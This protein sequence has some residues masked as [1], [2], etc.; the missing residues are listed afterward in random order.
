MTTYT[1]FDSNNSSVYRSGL[2]LAD[3]ADELLKTDGYRYEIREDDGLFE[4]FISERSENY[5][6]GPGKM[7]SCAAG[8]FVKADR[9]KL[10]QKIVSDVWHDMEAMPDEDFSVMLAS[11]EED[12]A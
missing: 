5:Y 11:F 6:G 2:S 12:E 10:L 3:A 9:E 1:V 7:I 4:L 8:G